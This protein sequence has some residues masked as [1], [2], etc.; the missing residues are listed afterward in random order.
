M[1]KNT[2]NSIGRNERSIGMVKK[3]ESNLKSIH[4]SGNNFLIKEEEPIKS[5]QA[6]QLPEDELPGVFF[7][8]VQYYDLKNIYFINN[9]GMAN[10]IDLLKSLLE[11]NVEVQFVNVSD[12]IK[13]KIVAMGLDHILI[14][15]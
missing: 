13:N 7:K 11:K 10:L 12:K 3:T 1:E 5:Y 8:G 4:L 9:T 2:I 15:A 14:C 6:Y